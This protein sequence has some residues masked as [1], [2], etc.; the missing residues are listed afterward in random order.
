MVKYTKGILFLGTP[1][2]GSDLAPYADAL[3]FFVSLTMVKHPNRSNLKV[4]RSDCETLAGIS[5][6]FSSLM[7]NWVAKVGCSGPQIYCFSEEKGIELLRD[8]MSTIN[9]QGF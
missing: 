4:L 9:S 8:R 6:S 3:G 1:H 2:S 5:E 7:N